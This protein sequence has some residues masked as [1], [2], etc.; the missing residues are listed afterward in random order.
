MKRKIISFI[1]AGTLVATTGCTGFLDVDNIGKSTIKSFFA[2]Y[3]GL[4]NAFYGMYRE[5][6]GFYDS[7]AVNYPDIA[8]DLVELTQSSDE[9]HQTVHNFESLP[10]HNAGYPRLIWKSGYNVV[11]NAN[12]IIYYGPGL[13]ENYPDKA[14]DIDRIIAH[15][16]FIR[17]L[18][19][20][21]LCD[22][23]GQNYTYTADASHLGIPLPLRPISFNDVVSRSTVQATYSCII[24]DINTAM[25]VLDK[26]DNKA[27]FGDNDIYY[28]SGTA[29]RALLARVYLYMGDYDKAEQY[30]S[31][32]ISKV[33]LTPHDK[34]EMMFRY[35]E[36]NKGEESILRLSGYDHT[37]SLSNLYNP[38]TD[39]KIVPSKKLLAL[40][41]DPDDLR[42][43]RLLHYDPIYE[44]YTDGAHSY[45][46]D[47][48]MKYYV[49]EKYKVD[50]K[51]L[52]GHSDPFVLR[53]SE[54][55]L[56]RAEALCNRPNPD[57][58]GAAADLKALI[59]RA[60]GKQASDITLE[61]A[62]RDGMNALIEQERMRELCFEGHRLLD[63][64]RR[65]QN[66][67]RE[68]SGLT[69]TTRINYP[70]YRFVLPICQLEMDNNDAMRQ[71]PGYGGAEE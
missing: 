69:T 39:T 62:G 37:S 35:P 36:E 11:T 32:V 71:N 20:L 59:A 34:Y 18:M 9:M 60:T 48:C 55:Y 30:A 29:C 12:N 49:N 47:A 64:T 17:A 8:S 67:V 26:S 50:N 70:D 19:F 25:A 28:A 31:D 4:E 61:Y 13:W 15:A 46:K 24:E 40:F 21:N 1:L 43:N 63:V 16:H 41:D 52:K 14:Q 2:E 22:A 56:I 65:H 53:C 66:M 42:R 45:E 38:A 44:G 57:L 68:E 33:S 54:M 5:T 27:L 51:G 10:E 23:Y 6:Y 3:S 7:Y 58:D